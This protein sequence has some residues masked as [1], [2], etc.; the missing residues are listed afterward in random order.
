M[1]KIID[2]S[3]GHQGVEVFSSVE[4]AYATSLARTGFNPRFTDWSGVH[5]EA[6][7]AKLVSE[8]WQEGGDRLSAEFEQALEQTI[9]TDRLVWRH[10]VTGAMPCVPS[11]LADSP[12]SMRTRRATKSARGPIN[13]YVSTAL[14]AGISPAQMSARGMAIAKF[15]L[16]MSTVRPVHLYWTADMASGDDDKRGDEDY[17]LPV[18]EIG[19]SPWDLNRMAFLLAHP[20]MFRVISFR[21]RSH[22]DGVPWSFY[23]AQPPA[24]VINTDK[25]TEI[26]KPVL[27][28]GPEDLFFGWAMLGD[29]MIQNPDAW[30]RKSLIA[31][32][33]IED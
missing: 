30:L 18:V 26:M 19:K 5:S 9:I 14:S 12:E 25:R 27:N 15:A 2:S 13:L 23:M 29:P 17:Y 32:G 16:F 11:Y 24:D 33:M 3:K 1:S 22:D 20:A 28:L 8:G 4:E 6:E 10:G 21:L 7:L 31:N